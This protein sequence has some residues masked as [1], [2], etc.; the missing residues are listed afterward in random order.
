MNPQKWLVVSMAKITKLRRV[1]AMSKKKKK[2]K[3]TTCIVDN[4][5][6]LKINDWNRMFGL[7]DN[8]FEFTL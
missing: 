8:E 2:T 6:K 1:N 3:K 7:V 5:L 4:L